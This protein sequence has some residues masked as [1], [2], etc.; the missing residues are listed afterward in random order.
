MSE[1]RNG[2]NYSNYGYSSSS[3]ESRSSSVRRSYP[4]YSSESRDSGES[5][6]YSTYPSSS[7]ESRDSGESRES[8]YSSPSEQYNNLEDIDR[9]I[10]SL[11]SS[12]PT[13]ESSNPRINKALEERKKKIAELK[14]LKEQSIR[15]MEEDRLLR[16]LE[17]QNDEVQDAIDGMKRLLKRKPITR[18]NN[19]SSESRDS[20]ESR[21]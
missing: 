20:G 12:L 5:R 14:Q 4:S 16:Q 10:E 1:S 7:S 15:K 9:L 18:R 21:W 13:I 3:S 17:S 6:S 8:V 2:N 19:N 11:E